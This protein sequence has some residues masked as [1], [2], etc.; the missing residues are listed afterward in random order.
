MFPYELWH[1]V[2]FIVNHRIFTQNRADT[3]VFSI[4]IPC[5]FIPLCFRL[6]KIA[7]NSIPILVYR[8]AFVAYH[9]KKIQLT[10]LFADTNELILEQ[11][12][13]WSNLWSIAIDDRKYYIFHKWTGHKICCRHFLH[14]GKMN[15]LIF[16]AILPF[17]L[18][19]LLFLSIFWWF[20]FY[21]ASILCLEAHPPCR[22]YILI[23]TACTY[24]S[25]VY[26][27]MKNSS[28]MQ[29]MDAKFFTR[30]TSHIRMNM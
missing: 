20:V 3:V 25:F 19:S 11:L 24:T 6:L 22:M 4:L 23:W 2:M 16:D 7:L 5:S 14:I 9:T 27:Y 30:F 1:L 13:S 26:R 8:K 15:R 18:F 29:W 17:F 28:I 10:S 21:K 12:D